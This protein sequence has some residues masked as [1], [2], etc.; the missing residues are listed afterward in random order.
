MF[1]FSPRPYRH[2]AKLFINCRIKRQNY[3]GGNLALENAR[4]KI[5]EGEFLTSNAKLQPKKLTKLPFQSIDF[6]RQD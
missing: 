3:V 1:S 5:G 4:L 2:M 6:E